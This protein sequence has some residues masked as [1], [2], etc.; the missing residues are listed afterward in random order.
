MRLII[1][2]VNISRQWLCNTPPPPPPLITG[3]KGSHNEFQRVVINMKGHGV[4][5]LSLGKVITVND[6]ICA[7]I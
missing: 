2:A 6:I 4:I 5:Y 7:V 3:N 1:H